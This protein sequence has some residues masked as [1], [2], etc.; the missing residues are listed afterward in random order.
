MIE[1]ERLQDLRGFFAQNWSEREFA[2]RGLVSRSVETNISFNHRKGT[3]RGMHYQRAPY[4]QV[5]LVRCTQGGIY[6]VIVDLRP[7]S[8]TFKN[9]IGVEL[10]AENR[11]MLYVPGDFAHGFQTLTDN[12]EV[13]Y[14][15]SEVYQPESAAGVRWDDPAFAIEWP[16]AAQRTIIERDQQYPDFVL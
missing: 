11:L 13:S 14:Q 4:A 15:M 12:T 1:P 2:A 5:K 9:W 6:D 10:T 8:A 16:P 7:D 3:L